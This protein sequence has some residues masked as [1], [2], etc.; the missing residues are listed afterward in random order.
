[1]RLHADRHPGEGTLRRLLDEPAGVA[2]ADREHVAG[3]P[4]CLRGLAAA[5]QDAAVAAAAMS[6]AADPDVDA[7]W[8]RFAAASAPA[9][10][11]VPARA[12]RWRTA[13]RSPVVAALGVVVVLGGAGA[14]AAAAADWL[15]IFRTEQVT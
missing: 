11:A 4:A 8:R 3:C 13:L 7:A 6:T 12:G 2:D 1:M 14:G 10:A 5:R 9:R 15:P